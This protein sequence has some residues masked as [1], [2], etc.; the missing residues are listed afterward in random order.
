L[1]PGS[2][3]DT[4]HDPGARAGCAGLFAPTVRGGPPIDRPAEPA[5]PAATPSITIVAT[6]RNEIDYV[7]GWVES[8]AFADRVV[9][10]DHG[11]RDGTDV[12]LREAGVEV[13]EI[14]PGGLIEDARQQVIDSIDEG[15]ILVLDLDERVPIEL[16]DEL[17]RRLGEDPIEAGF[18]IPFRHYVFG[19]WMRH[20][21]WRD[22][23]LRLFRA[24]RGRYLPGRIHAQPAVDGEVGRLEGAVVHFAHRSIHEFVAKMNRYTTQSAPALAAGESAGL[25]KRPALPPRPLRWLRAS[26]GVFWNRYIKAQGF[27]DGVAGFVVA[28]LL[29]AYQFVEQAKAWEEREGV[30]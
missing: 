23:H 17:L 9:V 6:A 3:S 11:S 12:A 22:A 10:G 24:G 4:M 16:R 30:A 18:R 2:P 14:P 1:S 20:G 5:A 13:V 28:V 8:V 27:R 26:G 15:W 21:G 7:P 29:A 19:R 25:R